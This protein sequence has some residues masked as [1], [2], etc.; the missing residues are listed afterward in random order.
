MVRIGP[1]ILYCGRAYRFKVDGS[2]IKKD[3]VDFG[4]QIVSAL[5]KLFLASN[6]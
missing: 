2:D 4:K 6:P 3:Q 5:E 1:V